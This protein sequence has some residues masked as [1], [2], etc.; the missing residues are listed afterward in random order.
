LSA[1]PQRTG[2]HAKSAPLPD[3]SRG[4]RDEPNHVGREVLADIAAVD[5]ART[6]PMEALGLLHELQQRLDD[7]NQET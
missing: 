2:G 6:T 3:P 7:T 1:S 5:V 4:P